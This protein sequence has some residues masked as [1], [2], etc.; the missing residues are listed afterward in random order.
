MVIK[1]E[2]TP[3]YVKI[4]GYGLCKIEDGWIYVGVSST[5]YLDRVLYD[6]EKSLED[7]ILNAKKQLLEQSEY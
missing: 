4:E 7:N 3:I 2:K 5:S 6:E 1:A